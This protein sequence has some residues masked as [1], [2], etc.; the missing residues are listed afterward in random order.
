[1]KT[2]L[3][4]IRR[5]D[6]DYH[7]IDPGDRIAV[8]ISGGKDSLLMAHGLSLYR[9]IRKDFTLQGIMLTMGRE[10]PDTSAVE[11]FCEVE[12]IPLVVRYT[13]LYQI[14][15]ELRN[16][17]SPCPLCA[18]MRR[19]MLCDM[20][21][22]LGCGKLALAHHR[23]DALETLLMSLIYEGRFHT[24]H[25]KTYM[26]RTGITVIRPM[27]YMPEKE[28][29]HMQKKL[30]LPVQQNACPANGNTKRQEM[31]ELLKELARRYPHLRETMLS[32]LKNDD[33][34]SLW[35]KDGPRKP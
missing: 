12:D 26:S 17:R 32:A 9:R 5:A 33:Q 25:P 18:K 10:A 35:E 2:T 21:K 31:K 6:Q 15:F 13:D 3:G 24:F 4:R 23:E 16:D 27:I 19:A 29:V 14:L 30:S 1:M 8:G 28:V 20:S 34:Y 7:L 11:A 22:E